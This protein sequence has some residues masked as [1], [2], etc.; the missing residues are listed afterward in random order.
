M[1]NEGA[2]MGESVP[3]HVAIIM[4]GNGRWAENKL[5]GRI[6]GHVAGVS[7]VRKIVRRAN[8]RGVRYLT[9]FAFSSENWNRPRT[10]VAA[11][12]QLMKFNLRREAKELAENNVRVRLLGDRSMLPEPA[13]KAAE[14]AEEI[15]KSSTGMELV[16]AISYGGRDEILE[17]VKGLI[18]EGVKEEEVTEKRLREHFYLPDLP[19]PDLVIRTSG[20]YRISNFLLWQIAYSEL[21]FT[22]LY[23]PDFD[24]KEFD[25]ALEVFASR[26]RRFGK[27]SAQVEREKSV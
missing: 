3:R 10:E 25:R 7:A 14:E 4:D 1:T 27:T 17:G 16:L 18:R 22:D 19:D 11:L 12:M 15:T 5:L 6:R 20:E 21:Y 23:W 9:L 24:E 8:D 26:E 13:L 2:K